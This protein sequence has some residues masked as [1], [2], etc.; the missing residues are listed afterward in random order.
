MNVQ[1]FVPVSYDTRIATTYKNNINNNI[2]TLR[3]KIQNSNI[4]SKIK[5]YNPFSKYYHEYFYEK[6][7]YDYNDIKCRLLMLFI[8]GLYGNKLDVSIE[9]NISFSK[10]TKEHILCKLPVPGKEI[11][12]KKNDITYY[13]RFEGNY[14]NVK[15]VTILTYYKKDIVPLNNMLRMMENT[16]NYYLK[17]KGNKEKFQN[18]LR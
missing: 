18:L 15:G 6:K 13:I 3:E 5:R 14:L 7:Y 4:V 11:E 8:D 2:D 16:Q 12:I 1:D 17:Y 10:N 9:Y